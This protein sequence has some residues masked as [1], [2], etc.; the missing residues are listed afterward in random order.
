M[1]CRQFLT[2]PHYPNA[3]QQVNRDKAAVACPEA[4][5]NSIS[6]ANGQRKPLGSLNL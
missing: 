6:Q 1:A 3:L 5:L 2:P 4:K